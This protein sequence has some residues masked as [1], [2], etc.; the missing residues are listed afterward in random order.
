MSL[1]LLPL[2]RLHHSLEAAVQGIFLTKATGRL[3]LARSAIADLTAEAAI[4]KLKTSVTSGH[5]PGRTSSGARHS[6]SG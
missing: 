6:A 1:K 5:D 4:F 3:A 2:I